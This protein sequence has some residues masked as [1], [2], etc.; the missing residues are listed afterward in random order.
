MRYSSCASMSAKEQSAQ[1]RRSIVEA[2]KILALNA[3]RGSTLGSTSRPGKLPRVR[4]A[5]SS[6]TDH[7]RNTVAYADPDLPGP[8]PMPDAT[9]GRSEHRVSIEEAEA[10]LLQQRGLTKAKLVSKPGKL[11]RNGKA[12]MRPTEDTVQRL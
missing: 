5:A 8:Q 9:V 2:E 4:H 12:V 11:P 10:M 3:S 7:V 6:S 1:H